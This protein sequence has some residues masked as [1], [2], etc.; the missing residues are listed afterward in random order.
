MQIP[1]LSAAVN[2]KSM[3]RLSATPRPK[4][5]MMS[6]PVIVPVPNEPGTWLKLIVLPDL[7]K[8]VTEL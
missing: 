5:L 7:S 3:K 1:K 8:K 6:C 4:R 2:L